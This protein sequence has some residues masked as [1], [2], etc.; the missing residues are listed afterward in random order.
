MLTYRSNPPSRLMRP[1]PP[2][3]S[4]DIDLPKPI[5]NDVPS[6][7]KLLRE[8]RAHMADTGLSASKFGLLAMNDP[9]FVPR[10]ISGAVLR[11][12]TIR[13]ARR[14]MQEKVHA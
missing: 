12:E 9:G 14:F 1:R 7:S 3:P 8:I 2:V 5:V 11:E 6:S 4:L 10:L 13:R